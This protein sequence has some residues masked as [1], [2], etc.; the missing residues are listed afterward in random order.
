MLLWVFWAFSGVEAISFVGS[1]VK[2]PRTSFMR[3]LTIGFF[4]ICLL[5]VIMAWAP[6]FTFGSDFIRD[7]S[8]L[9]NTSDA[10]YE[11]LKAAM[12]TT[13]VIPSIPFYAGVCGGSTWL[14]IILGCGFFFWYYNTAMIMY[15][16]AV[17]GL[18]AMAFDRQ[19]PMSWCAVSK[20]GAPTTAAGLL[21]CFL[22]YGDAHGTDTAAIAMA[23][24]DW[25]ALFFL[26]PVG[27]AAV[28]LPYTR[29]DLYEKTTF[30][31]NWFGIPAVSILGVIVL[32]I[33]WWTVFMV[34][35][36][37]T[38]LYSQI[39]LAALIALG[40]ALV[41]MMYGRNRKQG[42]DPNKIFAQIPPA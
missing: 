33:G 38:E 29:P 25:T 7:Y 17:R 31:K 1:E 21:G 42:I 8:Y 6:G 28:F 9:F 19:L 23:I 15:T 22:G 26:W 13:P 14:A 39:G 34:G 32:G 40:F 24:L 3:G 20:A 11:A 4:A 30:Q 5:Y 41:A 18:F 37:L 35:L 16:A 10:S 27:L 12:G 36:E 2:T